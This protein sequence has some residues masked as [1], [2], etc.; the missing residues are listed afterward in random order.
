MPQQYSVTA[1]YSDLGEITTNLWWSF[2]GHTYGPMNRQ[3]LHE[4]DQ[5]NHLP[6]AHC[7]ILEVTTKSRALS[8]VDS[9]D[10]AWLIHV[11]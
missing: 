2:V 1:T 5:L 11:F 6:P 9:I 8:L 4:L 7:V 3:S 10:R